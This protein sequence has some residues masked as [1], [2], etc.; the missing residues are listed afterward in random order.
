MN[1]AYAVMRSLEFA[2][3]VIQKI[4]ADNLSVV[5]SRMSERPLPVEIPQCPYPRDTDP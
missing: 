2:R 3:I 4:H 1:K 5:E